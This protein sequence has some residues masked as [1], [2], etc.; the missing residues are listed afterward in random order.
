MKRNEKPFKSYDQPFILEAARIIR[1]EP[2]RNFTLTELA[3]EVNINTNKL[4]EGFKHV[5]NMTVYEFQSMV[6]LDIAKEM[7]ED[8]DKPIKEIADKTGFGC[9][10]SFTRRFRQI[11]KMTPREWRQE[12]QSGAAP[13]LGKSFISAE[14]LCSN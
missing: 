11:Y 7:L 4:R 12:S 9:R 8:T 5:Y 14:A 6:R 2:S 1:K 10:S 13:P 3:L